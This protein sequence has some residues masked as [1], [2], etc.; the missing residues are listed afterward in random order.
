MR[1]F[2]RLA[3]LAGAAALLAAGCGKGTSTTGP[4]PLTQDAA[5]D[6]ALQVA[7]NLDVISG[8][9]QGATN[10]A[11][12]APARMTGDAPSDTSFTRGGITYQC[13]RTFYDANNQ[14]LP[15]WSPLAVRVV[16]TSRAFGTL[17]TERDT[18]TVGHDASLDVRNIQVGKDTLNFGGFS[19]DTLDSRS[20]SF[21]GTTWRHLN[22]TSHATWTDIAQLK[23]RDV[24]PYPLS[25]T[26]V[27]TIVVDRLRSGDGG[28]E[29]HF[30]ATVVVVFNGTATPDVTVNGQ[31]HYKLNLATGILVRA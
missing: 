5:D 7:A 12:A 25:G 31:W 3:L 22:T 1:S 17:M 4:A 21:D 19:D 29:S 14:V 11:V 2:T 10:F 15:G 20:R 26:M 8:D 23:N 9:V 13:A 18:A 24:N 16:W 30:T 28:I 6:A 27:W